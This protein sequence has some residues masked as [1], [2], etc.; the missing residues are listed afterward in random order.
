MCVGRVVEPA[1]VEL[2]DPALGHP[3]EV[4]LLAGDLLVDEGNPD[5]D[6]VEGLERHGFGVAACPADGEMRGA[7]GVL[8][9]ARRAAAAGRPGEH[10]PHA[11]AA[12]PRDRGRG[13]GATAAC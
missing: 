11:A 13:G 3:H 10:P 2:D 1:A 4:G 6:G 7:L 12:P 8:S 5:P 9:P